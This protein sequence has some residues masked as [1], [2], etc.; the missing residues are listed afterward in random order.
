MLIFLNKALPYI[1]AEELQVSFD[2]VTISFLKEL[3]FEFWSYISLVFFLFCCL[4]SLT[5][6]LIAGIIGHL[7]RFLNF[8][9]D[10]SL[11]CFLNEY[12]MVFEH[13]MIFLKFFRLFLIW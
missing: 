5:V 10:L 12:P 9:N 6:C 7:L 2:F 4:S 11:K 1:F 3:G 13:F 8:S